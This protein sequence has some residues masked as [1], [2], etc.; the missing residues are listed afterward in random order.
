MR[1]VFE[2]LLVFS[3][4]LRFFNYFLS[5]EWHHTKDLC[6]GFEVKKNRFLVTL[7][8]SRATWPKRMA[9]LFQFSN[10]IGWCRK[11]INYKSSRSIIFVPNSILLTSSS[12]SIVV[13]RSTSRFAF[14]KIII[15]SYSIISV[16]HFLNVSSSTTWP[17]HRLRALKGDLNMLGFSTCI[18]SLNELEFHCGILNRTDLLRLNSFCSRHSIKISIIQSR[19]RF[20]TNLKKNNWLIVYFIRNAMRYFWELRTRF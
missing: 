13:D 9:L 18:A 10:I 6:W 14:E 1:S 8:C 20:S 4:H 12:S 5:I 3:S 15:I 7:Y 16:N 2:N 17:D 11:K 19:F